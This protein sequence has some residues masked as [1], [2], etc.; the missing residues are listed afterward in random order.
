MSDF[1]AFTVIF[2]S[3]I[4][5]SDVQAF[6]LDNSIHHFICR[7]STSQ[8]AGSGLLVCLLYFTLVQWQYTAASS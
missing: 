3:L 7:G 5:E 6:I 2:Y 4:I 8:R 1:I